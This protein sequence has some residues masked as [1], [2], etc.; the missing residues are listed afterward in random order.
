MNDLNPRG[1]VIALE[2]LEWLRD[3]YSFSKAPS[4]INDLDET[5]AL[6]FT[7]GSFRVDADDTIEVGLR[8]YNDGFVADTRSSTKE[9]DAFL[10]NV[11]RSAA[12]KFKL[13]YKPE[14][15]RKKNYL[16]ELN[17]KSDEAALNDYDAKLR[18]FADKLS[19]SFGGKVELC[20]LGF[21]TDHTT[22]QDFSSFRFERK[23]NT[24]FSEHRYYTMAA[25]QTNVH[26][27]LLNE[28]ED[29]LAK[30]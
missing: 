3:S 18:G 13:S 22:P 12:K 6:T 14:I 29:V 27:K 10:D 28:L 1:K 5:K 21:W 17:V 24:S 30:K 2:L 23:Y 15:V 9:S 20:S 4:A 19:S 11:L 16:S 26:L 8:V 7:G 25:L